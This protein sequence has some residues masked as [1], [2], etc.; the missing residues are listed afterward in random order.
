[1][2]YFEQLKEP[3]RGVKFGHDYTFRISSDSETKAEPLENSEVSLPSHQPR[4][5]REQAIITTTASC[6][7]A[8]FQ[9]TLE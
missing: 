1:M 3:G 4:G 2:T 9:L 5:K 6:H 7:S 8:Q